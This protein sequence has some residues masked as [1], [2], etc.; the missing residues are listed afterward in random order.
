MSLIPRE[1]ADYNPL[2]AIVAAIRHH[3]QGTTTTGSWP[4]NTPSPPRSPTV[5]LSPPPACP[6][7]HASSARPDPC[8]QPTLRP[9][10]R[11][12]RHHRS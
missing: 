12:S 5:P 9:D 11:E 8:K 6:W 4:S 1:I 2:A 10:T 7:Q 3:T